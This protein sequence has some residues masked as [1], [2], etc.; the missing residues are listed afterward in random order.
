MELMQSLGK[1]ADPN[2]YHQPI[3]V[4][5]DEVARRLEQLRMMLTIRYAEEQIGDKVTDGTIRCPCHLAIGQEA[6]PVGLSESLLS[7]DK[8][9]GT[10]R[11]HGHYLALGSSVYQLFAE[12][13]GKSE[14]CSRGMGGSMH[15][16]AEDKGFVGSVPIVGATIPLA[17]GA[18]LALQK[19][20]K[21]GVAVCYFGDGAAEEGALHESMNFAA[22]FKLPVI[23]VCENNLF[24]SHLHIRLRQPADCVARYAQAHCM[25]TEVIEGNDLSVVSQ[26]GQDLVEHCR[27]GKGPAFLEAV[28]YRWRG[29]VGPRED[30]DVGLE[31]KDDLDLWKKRDPIMRLAQGLAT[32]SNFSMSDYE[33]LC[34]EVRGEIAHAW[35]LAEQ[36]PYPKPE[37]TLRYVYAQT[38][39]HRQEGSSEHEH[40]DVL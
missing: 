26:V 34:E 24:S 30:I 13:L 3:T 25:R 10:H 15:L 23:F 4:Q 16:Y 39:T 9:F 18:A 17:V 32:H 22:T 31:R 7:T 19:D 21:R 28:T 35:Q 6:I 40:T 1:L 33:K 14:G 20:G 38:S 8:V 37:A 5:A 12:V 27:S 36:A 29:H 11:S 2:E